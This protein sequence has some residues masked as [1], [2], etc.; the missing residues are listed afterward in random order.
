MKLHLVKTIFN[1]KQKLEKTA[2]EIAT[3]AGE[4]YIKV[5]DTNVDQKNPKYGYFELDW[6]NQFIEELLDAGYSLAD[7]FLILLL[8][9]FS[10]SLTF[11]N[12]HCSS[13]ALSILSPVAANT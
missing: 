9:K 3:E 5:L 12:N 2:K 6:N 11:D 10:V 4:P 13:K 7:K 8:I 1:K